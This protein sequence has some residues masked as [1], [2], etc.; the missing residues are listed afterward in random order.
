MQLNALKSEQDCEME[1]FIYPRNQVS[2]L[3]PHS[4]LCSNI[5]C[6]SVKYNDTWKHLN[7]NV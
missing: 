1:S 6:L 5:I 7:V 4:T 3:L 2:S